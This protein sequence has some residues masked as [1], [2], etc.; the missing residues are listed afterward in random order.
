MRTS[1]PRHAEAGYTLVELLIVLGLLSVLSLLLTSG[2]HFGARAWEAGDR[3]ARAVREIAI[4]QVRLRRLLADAYPYLS[5][6]DPANPHVE[7]D[8]AE[9]TLAFLGRDD[10]RAAPGRSAI[11]LRI[12]GGALVSAF[13]PELAPDAP[14]RESV[15]VRAVATLSFEY[16]NADGVTWSKTWRNA[17][18]LPR[19]VRVTVTFAQDDPRTWPELVVA[20]RVAADVACVFDAL[21]KTCVGR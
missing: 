7:F 5:T 4:A 12:G 20:P 6:A 3:S 9:R 19:L 11:A 10:E 16:L 21:A 13:R 1:A 2:L 14:A 17:R 8:G 15:L 18:T